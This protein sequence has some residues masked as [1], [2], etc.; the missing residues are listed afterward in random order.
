M[1][2]AGIYPYPM[3]RFVKRSYQ[4]VLPDSFIWYCGISQGI[5]VTFFNIL[6]A[7]NLFTIQFY[8][9]L[10]QRCI[11]NIKESHQNPLEMLWYHIRLSS[12]TFR[13]E[14]LTL[15]KNISQGTS[16]VKMFLDTYGADF[17][18][19]TGSFCRI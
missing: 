18:S 8:Y 14:S 17:W 6:L 9:G 11:S 4:K 5:L 1:L 3:Q 10:T 15:G 7:L 13:Y 12:S 16:H 2:Q 19:L